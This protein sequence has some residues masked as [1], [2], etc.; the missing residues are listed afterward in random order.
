[1]EEFSM[2]A[3]AIGVVSSLAASS[4]F[5]VIKLFLR[6]GKSRLQGY[7]DLLIAADRAKSVGADLP[8]MLLAYSSL[9]TLLDE[10]V[11]PS[12]SSLSK[13]LQRAEELGV[14]D[15]LAT[16]DFRRLANIRNSIAHGYQEKDSEKSISDDKVDK[17]LADIHRFVEL[18][19]TSRRAL[20]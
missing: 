9:E 1:M 8:S 6:A 5:A 13:K 16:Q 12:E 3:L 10:V 18:I 20:K 7:K 17:Y 4:V 14:L 15:H 2:I 19:E 11:S